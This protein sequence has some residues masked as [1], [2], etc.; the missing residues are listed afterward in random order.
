MDLKEEV[1]L[2]AKKGQQSFR[3]LC[4]EYSISLKIGIQKMDFP[5]IS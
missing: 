2:K 1:I 3:S 5:K 4:E